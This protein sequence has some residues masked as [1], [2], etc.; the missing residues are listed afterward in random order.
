M[1]ISGYRHDSDPFRSYRDRMEK[2]NPPPEADKWMMMEAEGFKLRSVQRLATCFS[3][4]AIKKHRR[5]KA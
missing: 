5:S 2:S 1:D 4:K 3:P